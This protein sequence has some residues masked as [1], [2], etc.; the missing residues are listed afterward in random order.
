MAQ[1]D[2][3]NPRS[4]IVRLADIK[5]GDSNNAIAKKLEP[6]WFAMP[7]SEFLKDDPYNISVPY[8]NAAIITQWRSK[9][10][11]W[12][13]RPVILFAIFSDKHKTNLVDALLYDGLDTSPLLKGLFEKNLR[14]VKVGDSMERV[15][16]LLGHRLCEYYKTPRGEWRVKVFYPTATA[17]D[18]N[19]E[20]IEFEA[21]ASSG[22]IIK[23]TVL[24][25]I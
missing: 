1:D 25:N 6:I 10:D 20:N 4:A 24:K 14:S 21:E 3:P 15:F 17:G 12:D 2:E 7:T 22:K 18:S 23:V 5:L 11:A 13:V 16:S 9:K 19:G 8:T